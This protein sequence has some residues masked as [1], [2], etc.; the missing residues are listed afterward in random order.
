MIQVFWSQLFVSPNPANPFRRPAI[1]C[2]VLRGAKRSPE[3]KNM[4]H[5]LEIER[6]EIENAYTT[7]H[8]QLELTLKSAKENHVLKQTSMIFCEVPIWQYVHNSRGI[9]VA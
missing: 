7:E 2:G 8:E 5:G 6:D 3:K 9:C 4:F 1:S